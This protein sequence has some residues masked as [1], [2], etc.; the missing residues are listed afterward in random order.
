MALQVRLALADYWNEQN[1]KAGA[2]AIEPAMC[3]PDDAAYLDTG[4]FDKQQ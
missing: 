1:S 3:D 4:E 2:E